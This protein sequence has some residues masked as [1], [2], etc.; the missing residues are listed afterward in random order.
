[1]LK[2]SEGKLS[3][4]E[5]AIHLTG[6]LLFGYF[7]SPVPVLMTLNLWSYEVSRQVEETFYAPIGFLCE[8]VDLLSV[9]YWY[10][11]ALFGWLLNLVI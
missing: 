2:A 8:R 3:I 6:W 10:Q 7:L 4:S 5:R 1:M 9:F 11:A